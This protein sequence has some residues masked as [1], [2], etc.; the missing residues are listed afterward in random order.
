M[1]RRFFLRSLLFAAAAGAV[2]GALIDSAV[3]QPVDSLAPQAPPEADL[4]A[5]GAIDAQGRGRKRGHYKMRRG[6]GYAWGRRSRR[7]VP[8]GRAYGWRRNRL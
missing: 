8:R 7:H 1:D 3:A 2:G 6:H 4:P 5:Q